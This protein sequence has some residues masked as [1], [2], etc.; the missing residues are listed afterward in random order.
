MAV[1]ATF[2]GGLAGALLV[3]AGRPVNWLLMPPGALVPAVAL[4][5]LPRPRLHTR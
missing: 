2:A 4:T 3:R 5:Y 1:L